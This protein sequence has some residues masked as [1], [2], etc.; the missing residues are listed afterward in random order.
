MSKRGKER[1][2][3]R[4]KRGA[5]LTFKNAG[6]SWY[7]S[8]IRLMGWVSFEGSPYKLSSRAEAD[9]P[10]GP[11]AENER[12]VEERECTFK[13]VAISSAACTSERALYH[14]ATS[15]GYSLGSMS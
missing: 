15:A 5:C 7:L 12:G 3:E 2:R 1:E 4:Q 11:S 14:V 10:A 8:S 9:T 13:P 6:K